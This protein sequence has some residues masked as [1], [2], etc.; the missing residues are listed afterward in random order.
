MAVI[1]GGQ[2]D[3]GYLSSTE[4][5]NLETKALTRGGD[6]N[7]ARYATIVRAVRG[8]KTSLYVI[9]NNLVEEWR[10][11]TGDWLE[12]GR[13]QEWRHSYAMGAVAVPP[14]LLC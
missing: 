6:L 10:E 1:A 7:S 9:G 2:G 14:G 8:G 4:L 13:L 12:V 5:I 11:E 3:G